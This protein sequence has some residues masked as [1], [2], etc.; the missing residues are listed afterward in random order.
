ML[1]I[2]L[3]ISIIIR[4]ICASLDEQGGSKQGIKRSSKQG[5]KRSSKEEIKR[6]SKEENEPKGENAGGLSFGKRITNFF[7]GRK[8]KPRTDA[9][10]QGQPR[11]DAVTQGQPNICAVCEQGFSPVPK[12]HP[13]FDAIYND[14]FCLECQKLI[15]PPPVDLDSIPTIA[16]HFAIA[17]FTGSNLHVL[18][19]SSI[20]AEMANQN[21]ARIDPP[22]YEILDPLNYERTNPQNHEIL[23]RIDQEENNH[24]ARNN[25]DL[26]PGLNFDSQNL[27]VKTKDFYINNY[28]RSDIIEIGKWFVHTRT[29]EPMK[30]IKIKGEVYK[31]WIEDKLIYV[32][33]RKGT[34]SESGSDSESESE[35]ERDFINPLIDSGINHE[36][37]NKRVTKHVV[38]N[39]SRTSN[40]A[41]KTSNAA[42][43]TSNAANGSGDI[44]LT[45]DVFDFIKEVHIKT[46]TLKYNRKNFSVLNFQGSLYIAG[47]ISLD[48]TDAKGISLDT[49]D[50]DTDENIS[51]A[52]EPTSST[53]PVRRKRRQAKVPVNQAKVSVRQAKVPVKQ[54]DIPSTAIGSVALGR[55]V[56]IWNFQ[57]STQF[58]SYLNHPRADFA[59]VEIGAQM[60]AIGG[61]YDGQYVM[62]IEKYNGRTNQWEDYGRM[63]SGISNFSAAVYKEKVYVTGTG[64]GMTGTEKRDNDLIPG[65]ENTREMRVTENTRE[66]QVTENTRE[67]RSVRSW[68]PLNRNGDNRNGDNRNSAVMGTWR[69]EAPMEF[70]KSNVNFFSFEARHS[71]SP[72]LLAFG[73]IKRNRELALKGEEFELDSSG[74]KWESVL[75]WKEF[76]DEIKD[77][78]FDIGAGLWYAV[79]SVVFNY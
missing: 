17:D 61:S 77:I 63:E 39:G 78:L 76:R 35:D 40:A 54:A 69:N 18:D 74:S 7:F 26:Y 56:E 47:G 68:T 43:K 11:T 27:S 31:Q 64:T 67:M 25:L 75:Y 6:S 22:N 46:V 62:E 20:G 8:S 3:K 42:N 23:E 65:T 19:G 33:G 30:R 12:E 45:I 59:L 14:A 73:T 71:R 58:H 4:I 55:V 41:N 9:V 38:S 72:Y 1:K 49:T 52:D 50:D 48:T 5:I 53:A 79:G 28:V 37:R 57:D 2:L 34:D 70:T 32:I 60:F 66:M 51:F 44:P 15:L 13:S 16:G 24:P 10:T 21:Y 36:G 29:Y